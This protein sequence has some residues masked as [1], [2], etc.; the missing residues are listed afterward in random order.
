VIV[1][2]S[3]CGMARRQKTGRSFGS[4]RPKE[5]AKDTHLRT[6]YAVLYLHE[7]FRLLLLPLFELPTHHLYVKSGVIQNTC[8]NSFIQ[9]CNVCDVLCIVTLVMTLCN[10]PGGYD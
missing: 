8:N 1:V 5:P 6:R 9:V 7:M 4:R 3:S 2:A 10:D